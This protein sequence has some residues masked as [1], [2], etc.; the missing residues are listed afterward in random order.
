VLVIVGISV[1]QA[2][3]LVANRWGSGGRMERWANALPVVSALVIT[4]VGL[5]MCFAS[6]AGVR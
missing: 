4:V 2:R 1:V 3:R 6:V 5:W